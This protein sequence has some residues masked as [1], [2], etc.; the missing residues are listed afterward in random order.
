MKTTAPAPV[1][2]AV[3]RK[4]LPSF[5]LNI[6]APLL[7]FLLAAP[8][9]TDLVALAIGAAIPAVVTLVVLVWRRRIDPIGLF[10]VLAFLVVLIVTAL[11]GGNPL[12][13][14]LNEAIITGPLGLVLLIS[15]AMG[16]PLLLTVR[17]LATRTGRDTSA[18]QPTGDR[19]RAEH[20]L[21]STITAIIGA[22]LFIHALLLLILAQ[23]MPTD[24]YL[25][26]GKPAG[27]I[28]LVLGAIPTISARKRLGARLR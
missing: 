5:L 4:L 15:T 12:I 28:V 26:V 19:A 13:L 8:Y 25:A 16:K 3:I 17:R 10:A 9:L 11:S 6:L 2:G 7:A 14:K 1:P 27:W 22:T 18:P 23:T 24:L 21:F 20:R